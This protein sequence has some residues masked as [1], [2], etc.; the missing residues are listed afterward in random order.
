M[1]SGSSPS[2]RRGSQSPAFSL[3]ELIL[4]LSILSVSA[5][6]VL[7][8][9][10]GALATYRT[11]AT[12]RRIAADLRAAQASA[13]ASSSTRSLVFTTG[14]RVAQYEIPEQADRDLGKDVYV[15]DLTKTPYHARFTAIDLGGDKTIIFN[16]FGSPD[17]GGEIY[18]QCERVQRRL[19]I[20][21][22]TGEVTIDSPTKENFIVEAP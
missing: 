19:T 17:S 4:V 8:R 21:A 13:R 16:G 15:V 20:D 3:I 2:N 10:S 11:E 18:V 7:P 12:A 1:R 22:D 14:V 9:Y 5:A 6:V